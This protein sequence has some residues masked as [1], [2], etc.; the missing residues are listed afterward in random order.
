MTS[1]S[2]SAVH[3]CNRFEV[4][5]GWSLA[6][7]RH[8]FIAWRVISGPRRFLIPAAYGAAAY[9]ALLGALLLLF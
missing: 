3:P 8:P 2:M 5:L 7:C 6:A 9:A 4:A 1:K